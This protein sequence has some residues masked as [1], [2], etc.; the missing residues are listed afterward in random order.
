MALELGSSLKQGEEADCGEED[1]CYVA[2][3]YLAPSFDSLAR[4]EFVLE[5]LCIGFVRVG[6]LTCYT[7]V[8]D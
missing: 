6:F 1:G 5:S 3:I 2:G 4:P 8:C 7:R